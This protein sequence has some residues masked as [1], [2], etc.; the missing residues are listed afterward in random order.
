M[1]ERIGP[2]DI[3]SVALGDCHELIDLLPDDSIDVLVRKRMIAVLLAT[4]GKGLSFF[5]SSMRSGT[6]L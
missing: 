2:F 3:D 4:L 5:R 6:R 1:P